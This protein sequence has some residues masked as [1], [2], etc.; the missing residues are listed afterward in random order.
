MN[1]YGTPEHTACCLKIVLAI[2]GH[3][4]YNTDS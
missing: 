2:G 4:V 1:Y 3:S